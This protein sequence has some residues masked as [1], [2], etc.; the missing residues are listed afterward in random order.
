MYGYGYSNYMNPYAAGAYGAGVAGQ[1]GAVAQPNANA[2]AAA[3]YNY[4]QPL[5]TAAAPPEQAAATQATSTFDQARNAFR[6]NDLSTASARSAGLGPMPND[7]AMHEF[8][9]LVLFAQG[10]YE[11]AAAPLYAVLSVGPG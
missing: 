4:T 10:K 11:Q 7:T 9:A 2:N 1:P 3:A 8:L 5:N 6:S